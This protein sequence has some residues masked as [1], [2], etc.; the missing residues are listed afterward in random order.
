MNLQWS[1]SPPVLKV[2]YLLYTNELETFFFT[3]DLHCH[4]KSCKQCSYSEIFLLCSSCKHPARSLNCHSSFLTLCSHSS[5]HGKAVFH[6]LPT[7]WLWDDQTKRD[8]WW[9]WLMTVFVSRCNV[10]VK[11]WLRCSSAFHGC[12][13][14]HID[15]KSELGLVQYWLLVLVSL[16]V[17]LSWPLWT[18]KQ[19]YEAVDP[20]FMFKENE[21][22]L[23]LLK[24]AHAFVFYFNLS[25]S[26]LVRK[27][28]SALSA[29]PNVRE[30]Q[31]VRSKWKVLA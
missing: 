4:C 24:Q 27:N 23:L 21:N 19:K 16:C 22:W 14:Y 5:R 2:W 11:P 6:I 31:T 1:N 10:N 25:S 12:D 29:L 28:F 15:R 17:V 18:E 9:S 8:L 13:Y 30:D 26:V 20:G 3:M 7:A